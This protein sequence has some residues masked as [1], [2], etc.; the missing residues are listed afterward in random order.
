MNFNN[1]NINNNEYLTH[2]DMTEEV[3]RLYGIPIKIILKTQN[4]DNI[5]GT[6]E[7]LNDFKDIDIEI[8]AL[9]ENTDDMEDTLYSIH[10]LN[11]TAEISLFISRKKLKYE[12][13]DLIGS[14][15]IMP[16]N[17]LMEITSVTINVPGINNMFTY[18]RVKSCYKLNCKSYFFNKN[19]NTK[20]ETIKTE[21]DDLYQDELVQQEMVKLRKD[22]DRLDNYFESMIEGETE[23]EEF[24]PLKPIENNASKENQKVKQKKVNNIKEIQEDIKHKKED[25]IFGRF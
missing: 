19:S 3:I 6:Y 17:K 10:G 24:I 21:Q 4:F 8:Y 7:D 20:L 18:N 2:N 15:V 23:I 1:F 5:F 16:S 12:P 9:P 14:V 22:F 11:S 25:D 13:K